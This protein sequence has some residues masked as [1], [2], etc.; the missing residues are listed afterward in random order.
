LDELKNLCLHVIID[1]CH[2]SNFRTLKFLKV[3]LKF[4]IYILVSVALLL[5]FYLY[6]DTGK[7]E[8]IGIGA[9]YFVVAQA[10]YLPETYKPQYVKLIINFTLIMGA[11]GIL[12]YFLNFPEF[13]STLKLVLSIN[14]LLLGCL[15]YVYRR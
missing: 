6:Y 5:T 2:S 8:L 10:I 13:N 11:A 12:L 1:N 14:T 15:L 7:S 3:N 9:L 4:L